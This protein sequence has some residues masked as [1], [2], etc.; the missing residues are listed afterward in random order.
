MFNIHRSWHTCS[1]KKEYDKN[2]IWN[3]KDFPP[4]VFV[5]MM[6]LPIYLAY[7]AQVCDHVYYRWMSIFE[8]YNI[9]TIK[10]LLIIFILL[11]KGLI[12]FYL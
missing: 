1:V 3:G 4:S 11:F 2:I 6:H 10:I 12:L 8:R 7:K 9:N 5:M